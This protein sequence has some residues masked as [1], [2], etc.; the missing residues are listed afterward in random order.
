MMVVRADRIAVKPMQRVIL[1][2]KNLYL[3]NQRIDVYA[4]PVI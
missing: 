1:L 3:E 2:L 4:R